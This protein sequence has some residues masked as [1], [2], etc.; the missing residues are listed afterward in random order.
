MI[1]A[2]GVDDVLR[3]KRFRLHAG[4]GSPAVTLADPAVGTGTFLLGVLRKIAET[5]QAD[6]GAG[7]VHGAIDAAVKRLIAFEMQLG[8]FAVAQLRI[9]AE[10]V[11]LTGTE[12]TEPVRMFVTN[13][14]GNPDDDEGWIP[15]M[16]A[17]IAQSRRA[18]NTIKREEPITVVLGNPPY[19]EKA[20]GRGGWIEG[21]TRKAEKTA[22]LAQWMPPREW[23]VGAHSK[24]LRNLYIYFWRWATWKVF[25][26][27]PESRAGIVCYITVAGFL[28]G[29]GFQKMRDYLRR[30]CDDIWVIDCSPEGHQPEVSTRIFEGVQQPVC[31][32]LASRSAKNDPTSPA[33]VR[34]HALPAGHRTE[35]F[36]ALGSL[37]LQ[38]AKAWTDCPTD[39]RAPFLPAPTGAWATYPKLEDLPGLP[40]D[41]AGKG[42]G[43]RPA[44]F[45]PKQ[46]SV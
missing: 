14:L 35:K 8:P 40:V 43:R 10:I 1:A 6:E 45:C 31:I 23:G 37:R 21:E 38:G 9:L 41:D 4:L 2:W 29:P 11:A 46:T 36:T 16:L 5:V 27:H 17:P 3:T 42:Q 25:D 30:T 28:G 12:P 32:V 22:P 34:F 33:K 13:T 44:R 19:K 15:G 18:A 20:K 24:H 26:H 39:W 7:A